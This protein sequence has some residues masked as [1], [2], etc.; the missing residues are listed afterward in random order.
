MC[1]GGIAVLSEVVPSGASRLSELIE[2]GDIF[3]EYIEI[4]KETERLLYSPGGNPVTGWDEDNLL[5]AFDAAG[6]SGIDMD[7][8]TYKQRRIIHLDDIENWFNPSLHSYGYGN[9]MTRCTDKN[10]MQKIVKTI[11]KV[12][13]G[14]EVSWS[15]EVCTISGQKKV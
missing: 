14:K 3:P 2:P 10:T 15:S 11:G 8:S 1:P 6:F 13:D 9:S 4:L 5:K 12:L 7:I